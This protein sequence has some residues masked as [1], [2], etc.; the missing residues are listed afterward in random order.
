MIS[1]IQ[2]LAGLKEEFTGP[3]ERRGGELRNQTPAVMTLDSEV[4]RGLVC[5]QGRDRVSDYA[6]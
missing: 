4:P 5:V 2:N 6:Q 3:S 1:I